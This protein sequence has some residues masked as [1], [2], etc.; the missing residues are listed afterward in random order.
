MAITILIIL[1]LFIGFILGKATEQSRSYKQDPDNDERLDRD[2]DWLLLNTK[3]ERY[4]LGKA[5]VVG[6]K[7]EIVEAKAALE[8]QIRNAKSIAI[9]AKM[10][11]LKINGNY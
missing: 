2:S 10:E 8:K 4:K 3:E 1:A 7:K 11:E 6:S 9:E 5:L